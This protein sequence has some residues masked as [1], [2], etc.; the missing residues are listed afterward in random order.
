[1][2][3]PLH[4]FTLNFH[5]LSIAHTYM[6]GIAT[7]APATAVEG[8]FVRV[9]ACGTEGRQTYLVVE[10]SDE[11]AVPP[12]LTEARVTQYVLAL[13]RALGEAVLDWDY[14]EHVAVFAYDDAR[15]RS[16]QTPLFQYDP[17]QLRDS[18]FDLTVD[19]VLTEL[20]LF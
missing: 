9:R 12:P 20:D 18:T 13:H 7:R 1:M 6:A 8:Y 4:V 2:S 11:V 10:F 5:K 14:A 3:D 17:R 19:V 16:R 15:T